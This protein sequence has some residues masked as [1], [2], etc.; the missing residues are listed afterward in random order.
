[1]NLIQK[2]VIYKHMYVNLT[3]KVQ[4]WLGLR[5]KDNGSLFVALDRK[6]RWE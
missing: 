3:I 1:M 5:G 2:D 4:R 6:G